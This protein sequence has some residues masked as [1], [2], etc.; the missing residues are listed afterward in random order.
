MDKKLVDVRRVTKVVKGGRTFRFSALVVVGDKK[1]KVGMAIGK[2]TEVP[3]AIEKAT[4]L[5]KRNMVTVSMSGTTIP[6]EIIGKYGKSSVKLMPSKEGTGVIAGGAV[7]P[8]VEL[9]G[10]KDITA[11]VYG[12]RNK[13]NCVRATINALNEL[14]SAQEIAA[15]RGKTVEEIL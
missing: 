13:I 6:H 12:S 9:C 10:I 1:G 8:V 5:A 4:N 11:K 7:R 3:M 15:L 14:R 2:A